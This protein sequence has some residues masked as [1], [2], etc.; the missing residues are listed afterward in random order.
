MPLFIIIFVIR[1]GA[2][3]ETLMDLTNTDSIF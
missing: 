2:F 1:Q 3:E